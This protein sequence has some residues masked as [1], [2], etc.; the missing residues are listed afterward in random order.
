MMTNKVANNNNSSIF[1]LFL[2]AL[3][4]IHTLFCEVYSNSEGPKGLFFLFKPSQRSL[5]RTSPTGVSSYGVGSLFGGLI[6]SPFSLSW[7]IVTKSLQ[8]M[9]C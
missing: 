4:D 8:A 1:D 5:P 9:P 6:E 3:N 7:G 2:I